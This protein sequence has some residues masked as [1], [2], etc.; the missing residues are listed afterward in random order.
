MQNKPHSEAGDVS[1]DRLSCVVRIACHACG[2]PLPCVR[3]LLT[4]RGKET[5]HAHG[6]DGGRF[7]RHIP[8]VKRRS[9]RYLECMD[10]AIILTDSSL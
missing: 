6:G 3:H 2:I 1:P 5:D 8:T 7:F 4:M 9:G 10:F